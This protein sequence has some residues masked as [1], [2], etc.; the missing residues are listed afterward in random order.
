[1]NTDYQNI[2]V[3]Q[4]LS[5]CIIII[6]REKKLN[7]LSKDTLDELHHAIIDALKE[8]SIKGIILTGMGEKAFVAGAD[9]DELSMLDAEKGKEL[10]YEAQSKVFNIIH[11]ANKPVIA[12]TN[13]FALGG[14]LELAMS[15]HMR[16]AAQHALMGLPEVSLGLIPGYGGTQRLTQLVGRGYA[17]EIILTGD[18]INAEKALSIG[19]VN[20][21]VPLTELMQKTKALLN[22]IAT[23]SPGAVSAAIRAVNASQY[24]EGYETEINEFSN[25]F[26]TKEFKEGVLAFLEKRNPNF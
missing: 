2:I 12:A 25:L 5:T 7:A 13:G 17:L 15:C 8:T 20:H 11:Q 4:D 22:K 19:L 6:N 3:N 9:I 16:I 21:V 18:M 10:A 24:T 14:G 26:G 23:R 1:M